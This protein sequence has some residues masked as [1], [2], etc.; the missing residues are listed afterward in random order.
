MKKKVHMI[1]TALLTAMTLTACGE[2]AALT[3]FKKSMDDFCTSISEIDSSINN[4]DAQSENATADLLSYLDALDS[5]FQDF[6]ELDF[7]DEFDYLENLADESSEYMTEAVKSYHEAYGNGAY[8]EYI[9]EYAKQN[10]SRAYKRIQIIISFLHGEEPTDADLTI[11][12]EN[13]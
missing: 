6:A 3:Q 2:D 7:P 8:N 1:F 9:A 12:Y 4:I 13:D 11:E 5:T 10:Y